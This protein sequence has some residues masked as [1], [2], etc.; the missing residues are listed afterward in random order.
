MSP[1]DIG[2]WEKKLL[3]LFEKTFK[4]V[5]KASLDPISVRSWHCGASHV[6]INCVLL[7]AVNQ[8]VP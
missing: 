1:Q 2:V 3:L 7:C 8:S 4:S 6:W 5:D